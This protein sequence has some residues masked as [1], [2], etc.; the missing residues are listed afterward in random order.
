[1]PLSASNNIYFNDFDETQILYF[2]P[3]HCTSLWTYYAVAEIGFHVLDLFAALSMFLTVTIYTMY[4]Q[5]CAC[6]FFSYCR[7]FAVCH[8]RLLA[9]SLV[10]LQINIHMWISRIELNPLTILCHDGFFV[11]CIIP[12]TY[13]GELVLGFLA[14]IHKCSIKLFRRL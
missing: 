4:L 11:K 1:M 7:M 14:N 8:I 6:F 9:Y 10:D 3:S 5:L 12:R 2:H 13:F